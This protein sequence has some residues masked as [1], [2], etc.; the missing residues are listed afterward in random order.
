[1]SA[2]ISFLA[3]NQN[4]NGTSSGLGFYGSAF[5]NSVNVGSYQQTTYITDPNGTIQGPQANNCQFY[6]MTSGLIG[7]NTVPTGVTYF[8]NYQSTLN[9][10][11][12]N[13]TPVKAQNVQLYIYDRVNVNNPAS[14]VITQVYETIHPNTVQNNTGSGA[15]TWTTFSGIASQTGLYLTLSN[16]PG[17]SGAYAGNGSNSTRPDTQHDWYT[18]ISC[19]PLTIGSKNQFGL[20][21]QLQYLALLLTLGLY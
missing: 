9:I 20:W 17:M 14:G 16:S 18:C 10:S 5:G 2:Q 3:A 1:M 21:V 11:F 6:S 15:S 8:P 13:G 19:T 7:T 4:I 12:T